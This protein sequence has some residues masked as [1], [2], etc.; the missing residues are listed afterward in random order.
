MNANPH[1]RRF[2]VSDLSGDEISLHPGEAHHALHVLRLKCGDEVE[3]FDGAGALA[4]A[5]IGH[6][7]RR[8][9]VM[10]ITARRTCPP[11]APPD[12][13]LAFAAPKPN[14]LD[15]LVEKATELGAAS[16]Q[17]V[18][19]DRSPPAAKTE[20]AAKSDKLL[21]RC[22]SAAKQSGLNFLP[23]LPTP[24]TLTEILTARDDSLKLLGDTG[25]DAV[26]LAEAIEGAPPPDTVRLLIGPE[27]GLTESERGESI[28][29]GFIPVR[30]ARTTLRTETAAVALLAATVASLPLK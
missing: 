24:V 6:V 29:S 26:K 22:I 9:V 15:W 1:T 13:A 3:L 20:S 10:R 18:I 4:T 16:L 14:R 25:P 12:I 7:D 21:V 8:N 28:S 17:R 5:L 19:F 27:G 30:V 23:E 2:F 11:P